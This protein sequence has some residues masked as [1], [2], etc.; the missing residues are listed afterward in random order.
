MR[1]G[2]LV[3]AAGMMLS[4]VLMAASPLARLGRAL[5]AG[6]GRAAGPPSA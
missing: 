1:T 5:P 4:P 6:P 3:A 2:L